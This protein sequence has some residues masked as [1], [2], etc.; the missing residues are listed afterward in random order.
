MRIRVIAA[1]YR[2]GSAIVLASCSFAASARESFPACLAGPISETA[3]RVTLQHVKNARERE[4]AVLNAVSEQM[5]DAAQTGEEAPVF[6]EMLRGTVAGALASSPEQDA[7][8]LRAALYQRLDV[9]CRLTE[10]S[11]EIEDPGQSTTTV[12]D[13]RTRDS[14][15]KL[16]RNYAVPAKA[17]TVEGRLDELFLKAAAVPPTP[18]KKDGQ[19]E[20]PR[21]YERDAEAAVDALR[22]LE[23]AHRQIASCAEEQCVSNLDEVFATEAAKPRDCRNFQNE[24]RMACG[25][26]L[27]HLMQMRYKDITEAEAQARALGD[28]GAK[29]TQAIVRIRED[30]EPLY[31][32]AIGL[33]ARRGP[34]YGL[35][36]GPS[37]LMQ[38]DGDWKSGTEILAKF[39]TES[40]AHGG[41][42]WL[43]S[44]RATTEV[45][46]LS[47]ELK[48]PKE[49]DSSGVPVDTFDAKGRFRIREIMREHFSD[50][51]GLEGGVGVT[52]PVRDSNPLTHVEP[53]INLGAHFQ[54]V[55]SDGVLGDLSIGYAYD[56][57]WQYLTGTDDAATDIDERK[58]QKHFDR[59][60]MDGTVLFPNLDLGGWR[61]AGRVSADW[62]TGGGSEGELRVSILFYYPF[63][64]WLDSFQPKVKKTEQP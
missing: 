16:K 51:F 3:L 59:L 47:P 20:P 49:T 54:T 40:F 58:L 10:R 27:S 11:A 43:Q 30:V 36:A 56:K 1:S 44:C 19:P 22:K 41:L 4:N 39:D 25:E 2:L 38:K 15:G 17:E 37:M 57:Y 28:P 53:R 48:F 24:N 60:Y 7:A 63:N 14:D 31:S 33:Q 18:E 32:R 61:L 62:P 26:A 46:F 5:P 55:Y 64:D 50:W 35:F 23:Y 12:A 45:S 34:S 13:Q 6:A 42:C 9:F 8:S 29:Q 52:G 21:D